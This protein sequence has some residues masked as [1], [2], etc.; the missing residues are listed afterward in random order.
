MTKNGT[1][2]MEGKNGHLFSLDVMLEEIS[3]IIFHLYWTPKCKNVLRDS[4]HNTNI[5]A[6]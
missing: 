1:T 2:R 4:M 3:R 6:F 5:V